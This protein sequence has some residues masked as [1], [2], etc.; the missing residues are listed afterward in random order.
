MG[1]N[2]SGHATV[3]ETAAK[4]NSDHSAQGPFLPPGEA[5]Q[6]VPRPCSHLARHSPDSKGHVFF[7]LEVVITGVIQ[8]LILW[9]F[10]VNEIG[11]S[12]CGGQRDENQD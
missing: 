6:W 12:H 1:K 9:F 10:Q 3:L 11:N 4:D 8:T 7:W 5:T 2:K